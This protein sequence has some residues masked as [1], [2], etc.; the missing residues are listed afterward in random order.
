MDPMPSFVAH[1]RAARYE[2][3]AP[4]VV[5]AAKITILDTMGAALAGSASEAGR[6]MPRARKGDPRDPF[7]LADCV[8][9]FRGWAEAAA[10]PLP[11]A[12]LRRFVALVER[13]EDLGDAAELMPLLAGDRS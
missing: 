5:E 2:D 4:E 3:L 12:D 10:R 7:T 1:L 11:A 8:E 13:L 9:R 6:G